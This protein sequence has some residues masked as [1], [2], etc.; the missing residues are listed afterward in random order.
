MTKKVRK[1]F[2]MAALVFAL[3]CMYSFT[4]LADETNEV[5]Y[6]LSSVTWKDGRIRVEGTFKNNSKNMD[7]FDF[8]AGSFL[9]YDKNKTPILEMYPNI[10]DFISVDMAPGGTWNYVIE[11]GDCE[12]DPSAFDVSQFSVY[13]SFSYNKNLCGGSG[14]SHCSRRTSE[15]NTTD[16]AEELFTVND[17]TSGSGNNYVPAYVPMEFPTSTQGPKS[18]TTCGGNCHT[19]CHAN[20]YRIVRDRCT[21]CTNGKDYCKTCN[22]SGKIY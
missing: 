21:W 20:D 2:G 4:A 8:T 15:N 1:L 19:S 9:V 13:V 12:T 16:I 6:K 5:S 18:C 22:G 10:L 14:C 7:I 11:R 17:N 3:V